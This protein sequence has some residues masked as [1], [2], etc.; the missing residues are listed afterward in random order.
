MLNFART[1]KTKEKQS[2]TAIWQKAKQTNGESAEQ[3]T[4][5]LTIRVGRSSL[6]FAQPDTQAENGLQFE[7]Y[8]SRTGV[9]VAANLREA[10][11]ECPL[12]EKA[13]ADTRAQVLVDT[14][15]MLVPVEEFA[16][17]QAEA[18]FQHTFTGNKADLVMWTVIPSL[19]AVAV[20]AVNKD[21][22]WWSTTIS[23]TFAGATSASQF[24]HICTVAASQV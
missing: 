2:T 12:L 6:M 16:Q 21:L 10:F 19:N 15:L 20:Y 4:P 1:R 9:S 7:H 11:G 23:A 8:S 13:G 14:P 18:L 22:N 3:T 17:H 24:G 5:R